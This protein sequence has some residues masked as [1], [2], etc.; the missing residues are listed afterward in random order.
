[1][2]VASPIE[3]GGWPDP[4]LRLRH[5]LAKREECEL[6]HTKRLLTARPLSSWVCV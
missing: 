2:D 5:P 3:T 1:M 4:D 6:E